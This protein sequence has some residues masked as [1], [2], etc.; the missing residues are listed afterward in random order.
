[1]SLRASAGAPASCSG[2]MYCSVPTNIPTAVRFGESAVS[3]VFRTGG[4]KRLERL[5]QPEVEQLH[6]ALASA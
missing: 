6:A 4:F 1:M 3:I 5:R 2:A